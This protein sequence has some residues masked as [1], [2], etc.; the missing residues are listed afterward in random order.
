MNAR[1][2]CRVR[3]Q[4]RDEGSAAIEAAILFPIVLLLVMTIIQAAVYYHAQDVVQSAANG[5]AV[6][7]ALRDGTSDAAEAEARARIERAG[8]TS[9]LDDYDVSATHTGTEVTITVRGTAKTFIPG[10]PPLKVTQTVIAPVER[11]TAP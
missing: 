4:K 9:L 6:V 3:H 1:L 5:G 11:F 10:L 2:G 7:G 8:G